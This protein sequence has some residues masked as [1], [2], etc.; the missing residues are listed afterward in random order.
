MHPH[1]CNSS[2]TSFDCSN[3]VDNNWIQM[4][5]WRNCSL[6]DLNLPPQD[7]FTEKHQSNKYLIHYAMCTCRN[8][9]DLMSLSCFFINI[10]NIAIFSKNNSI[11][12]QSFVFMQINKL[13]YCYVTLVIIFIKYSNV[14]LNLDKVAWFQITNN[15]NPW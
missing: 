12:Y 7:D 3:S 2:F 13:K 15:N 1:N 8:F 9:W 4:L 10:D 5:S 11:K 14:V 6:S